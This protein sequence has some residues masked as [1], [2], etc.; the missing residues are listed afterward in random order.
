V[1]NLSNVI[2]AKDVFLENNSPMFK[3]LFGKIS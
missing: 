2:Y 1:D 3:D